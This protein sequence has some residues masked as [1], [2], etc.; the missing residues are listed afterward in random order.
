MEEVKTGSHV[1]MTLPIITL[2]MEAEAIIQYTCVFYMC[3]CAYMDMWLFSQSDVLVK[4]LSGRNTL[5]PI[6]IP[7]QFCK[8]TAKAFSLGN[9]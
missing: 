8:T 9:S 3:V 1:F 6:K 7:E 5:G 4:L 2:S